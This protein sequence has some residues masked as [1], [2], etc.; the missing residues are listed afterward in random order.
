MPDAGAAAHLLPPLLCCCQTEWDG[1][2]LPAWLQQPIPAP[3]GGTTLMKLRTSDPAYLAAVDTW[4]GALLPLMAPLTY[5]KG[6]PIIMVQ[7]ENEYGSYG[8]D[9][10]YL[11]HLSGLVRW[12]MGDQVRPGQGRG[13]GDMR[14]GVG[15][16]GEVGNRTGLVKGRRAGLVLRRDPCVAEASVCPPSLCLFLWQPGPLYHCA[17]LHWQPTLCCR[18]LPPV[19]Y[20]SRVLHLLSLLCAWPLA[21]AP[22]ANTHCGW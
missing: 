8:S 5:D 3:G 19:L 14:M 10:A 4:F 2:G 16:V 18:C 6:G 12:H 1:G 11:R 15:G 13:K 20:Q 21:S 22:L 17:C 7:I 9:K